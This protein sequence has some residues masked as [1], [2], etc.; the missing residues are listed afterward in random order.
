MDEDTGLPSVGVDVG[1]DVAV[2]VDVL[3]TYLE[4]LLALLLGAEQADLDS[5]LFTFPETEERIRRF[6]SD[7]Q[8][9]ALYVLKETDSAGG[10]GNGKLDLLSCSAH[11]KVRNAMQ[12]R[13]R[14]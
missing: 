10:D 1:A 14:R 6:A 9:P 7:P 13:V 2:D 12:T 8:T 3:N 4:K 11:I 5:S